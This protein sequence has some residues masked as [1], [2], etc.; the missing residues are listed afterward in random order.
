[1]LARGRGSAFAALA[2]CFLAV[3]LAGIGAWY[4]YQRP[5]LPTGPA[6]LAVLPLSN[7]SGD[8]SLQ[9]FADRTTEDLIAGLSRSPYIKVIART[10]TDVYKD[11][12]HWERLFPTTW[13]AAPR[14][15]L[16]SRQMALRL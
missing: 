9:Y 14:W 4:F 6:T 16:I 10:S 5:S 15:P 11:Q 2:L 1:M 12:R 13:R 8:T 7:M 3:I